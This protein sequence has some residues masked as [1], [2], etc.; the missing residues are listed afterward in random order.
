MKPRTSFTNPFS[1]PDFI[2]PGQ[3]HGPEARWCGVCKCWDTGLVESV[4]GS[5]Y[6]HP[7]H[8]ES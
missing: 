7:D 8:T 2:I 1:A 5:I 6:T 3:A 4:D